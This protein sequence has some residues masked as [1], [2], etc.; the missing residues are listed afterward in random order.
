MII[1][2]GVVFISLVLVFFLGWYAGQHLDKKKRAKKKFMFMKNDLLPLQ[3]M[4]S[5]CEMTKKDRER[6]VHRVHLLLEAK[7]GIEV[8][9]KLNKD[10]CN[11]YDM[12]FSIEAKELHHFIY[13]ISTKSMMNVNEHLLRW[14]TIPRNAAAIK[15]ADQWVLAE[16]RKRE[17]ENRTLAI[18]G[19]VKVIHEDLDSGARNKK[20]SKAQLGQS[21]AQLERH[22]STWV[23]R[24]KRYNSASIMPASYLG[25]SKKE[26]RFPGDLIKDLKTLIRQL[27]DAQMKLD[28][29]GRK[30]N[31]ND[32]YQ[33][34]K[35]QNKKAKQKKSNQKSDED[36]KSD[37]SDSPSREEKT[38]ALGMGE[39][40]Q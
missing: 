31:K 4:I 24:Y 11:A 17:K 3:R 18:F 26:D 1:H 2:G 19:H 25:K 10:P 16:Y 8:M 32:S 28:E 38:A 35:P 23:K 29:K 6:I 20:E 5:L 9:E 34:K 15:K 30:K 39:P 40:N 37:S 13:E 33:D 12:L 14:M 22:L 27:D 7:F 21:S 36:K